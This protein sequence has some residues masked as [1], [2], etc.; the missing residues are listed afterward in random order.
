MSFLF[1]KLFQKQNPELASQMA[2]RGLV[3]DKRRH[4]W[5]KG[6]QPDANVTGGEFSEIPGMEGPFRY[7]TGNTYYYSPKEGK[8]Y[9]RG[10]DVFMPRGFDPHTGQ[11]HQD[12]EEA[13]REKEKSQPKTTFDINNATEWAS[14]I[15]G[16]VNAPV[17]QVK[18][19]TLGGKENVSLLVRLSLD[20]KDDWKN[21]IF[22]NSRWAMIS[23]SNDGEMEMPYHGLGKG[24]RMR[25][26][27]FK[28]PEDATQKI[29]AWIN[30]VK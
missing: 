27:K 3:F 6:I 20:K 24:K 8:Y 30:K 21:G 18:L 10:Q 12:I 26:T 4:R 22:E 14:K 13:R 28:S 1:D 16:A 2:R 25:N 23:L 9:D 7:K 11:Y 19:S 17:S 29:N 5:V 15:K